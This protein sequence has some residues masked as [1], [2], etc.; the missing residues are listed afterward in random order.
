MTIDQ[1]NRLP[2]DDAFTVFEQC[3][4]AYE[5]VER[6]VYS[7]P[8]EDLGEVLE[9]SDNV[10]DECDVDDYEEAFSF[11]P[12]IGHPEDLGQYKNPVDG[13]DSLGRKWAA[14]ELK[15]LDGITPAE[16][17]QLEQKGTAYEEKFGYLYVVCAP[18]KSVAEVLEDLQ[19]R[20]GNDP[21]VEIEIAA[22]EQHKI[23][24]LRLKKLLA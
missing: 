15:I 4:G 12:R 19:A 21:K 14:H 1:L 17:A 22:A 20:L 10:W 16:L 9:T 8:F 6:M 11:F 2:E 7:R 18:G 23:T 13:L 5:W 3:C 24:Q